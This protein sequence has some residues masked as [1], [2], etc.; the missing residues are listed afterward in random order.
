MRHLKLK[1]IYFLIAP[2]LLCTSPSIKNNPVN[3]L[4]LQGH[5]GARGLYPENT[6]PAFKAAMDFK[7]TTIE[8]DTVLTKDKQLIIHHDNYINPEICKWSNGKQTESLPIKNFTVAELKELDCGSLKNSRFPEQI[9]V[10][11]T[12]LS[13]LPEFFE[14]VKAYEKEKKI[15]NPFLYNIE[16]KINEND[17]S[18]EEVIE[19]ANAM[20]KAIEAA[21]VV[22]IAT[23][24]SFVLEVLPEVKKLNPSIQISALYAPSKLDFIL[25]SFGFFSPSE[26]IIEKTKELNAEIISPYHKYVNEK[27]IHMCRERKIKVIPWTVNDID[28]MKQLIDYGVDGIISD[29]PNR[30]QS[31]QE[32]VKIKE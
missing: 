20:V 10:P 27:F 5:R 11:G 1:I 23:V 16:T 9:T 32:N 30:L 17:Y 4:D 15:S 29:Y 12:K 28:L 8:L 18:M 7:M 22:K 25:L 19:Y 31:I 3:K 26:K 24:Q 21:K 14:F 2:V 6:I 13:T